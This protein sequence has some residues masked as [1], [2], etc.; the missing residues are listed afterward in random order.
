MYIYRSN[1]IYKNKHINI[2]EKK[3]RY[4]TRKDNIIDTLGHTLCVTR[5]TG[6]SINN[7]RLV[8]EYDT[9]KSKRNHFITTGEKRGFIIK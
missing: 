8:N 7:K 9:K 3:T 4:K 1:Q 5:A 2:Y 6:Y